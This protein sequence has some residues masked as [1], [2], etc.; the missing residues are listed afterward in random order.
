MSLGK[1]SLH[2]RRSRRHCLMCLLSWR[3]PTSC[4]PKAPHPP[5]ICPGRY[6]LLAT[7]G[8]IDLMTLMGRHSRQT[9]VCPYITALLGCFIYWFNFAIS[10]AYPFYR[11]FSFDF[12]F[13]YLAHLTRF[14]ILEWISFF[15]SAAPAKFMRCLCYQPAAPLLWSL[16]FF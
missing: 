15:I 11:F 8:S 5:S 14:C 16:S 7:T 10:L 6:L 2:R 1:L 4:H 3:H 13:F 9:R 12:F